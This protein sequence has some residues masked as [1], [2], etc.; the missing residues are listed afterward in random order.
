MT[1]EPRR[2]IAVGVE[3][4]FATSTADRFGLGGR[5]QPGPEA[6]GTEVFADPERLNEAG[7]APRPPVQP[8]NDLSGVISNEDRHQAPVVVTR[9]RSNVTI[10]RIAKRCD[11]SRARLV[12][13]A[14]RLVRDPEASRLRRGDDTSNACGETAGGSASPPSL[15]VLRG[16]WRSSFA[17]RRSALR[18]RR[19]SVGRQ[20][21]RRLAR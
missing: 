16:P 8:G 14:M 15:I 19:G 9:D 20:P 7:P 2:L 1:I 10:E 17:F 4:D 3:V 13:D 18:L 5:Q 12:L 11:I 21:V 6:L